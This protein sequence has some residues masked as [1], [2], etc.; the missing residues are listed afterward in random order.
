VHVAVAV[1]QLSAVQTLPSL[2]DW[3]SSS[4][5]DVR[6]AHCVFAPQ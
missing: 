1:S 2:H 4:T 3:T 5:D 6:C